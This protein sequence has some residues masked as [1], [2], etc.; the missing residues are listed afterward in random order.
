MG[1][2]GEQEHTAKQQLRGDGRSSTTNQSRR[3][4]FCHLLLST[5]ELRRDHELNCPETATALSSSADPARWFAR[6]FGFFIKAPYTHNPFYLISAAL[7]LYGLNVAFGMSAEQADAWNLLSI[8]AGYTSLMTL[9]AVLI[10]RAGEVWED[11]RSMLLVIVLL[12]LGL[13]VSFDEILAM[14]P[15]RGGMFMLTGLLF[16]LGICGTLL[17]LLKIR[18]PRFYRWP[19]FAIIALFF[20]YPM[21]LTLLEDIVGAPGRHLVAWGIYLFPTVAGTVFLALI[22]AIRKGRRYVQENDTPWGWP[23][24]PWVLFGV[25]G[26]AVVARTHMLGLSFY[27]AWLT[28]SP[29]QTFFLVPF[30]LCMGVLM[31]ELGKATGNRALSWSAQAVPVLA[32]V[33]CLF[34]APEGRVETD[35][36]QIYTPAAGPPLLLGAVLSAAFYA[37]AWKRGARWAEAGVVVSLLAVSVTGPRTLGPGSLVVPRALPLVGIALL[38]GWRAVRCRS[39]AHAL[40]GTAALILAGVVAFRGTWFT[41]CSGAIPVHVAALGAL[42]IGALC[43]DRLARILQDAG[44]FQLCALFAAALIAGSATEV[45]ART[46]ILYAVAMLA[47]QLGYGWLMRNRFY[48]FGFLATLAGTALYV[49]GQLVVTLTRGGVPE[50]TGHVIG[51]AV[52]FLVALIISCLKANLIQKGMRWTTR[53]LCGS[54]N[55]G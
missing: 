9:A 2:H 52:F 23:A 22:P 27:P 25:L 17:R 19:A 49:G 6:A 31:L 34:A 16:A 5:P 24:F 1:E 15:R 38:E 44:A 13:S 35:F 28:G 33:L 43:R 7:V 47:T 32:L 3:C 41:T 55:G 4:R 46:M 21:G 48:A 54:G 30:L 51:G 14:M 29:F 18:L 39:S 40:A 36:L 37:Y 8:L 45:P 50:G 10:V 20:G 26:G 53:T 42:A 11:A 12:L